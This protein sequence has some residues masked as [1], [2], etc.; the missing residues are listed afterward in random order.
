MK[1]GIIKS[2]IKWNKF[3]RLISNKANNIYIKTN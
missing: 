3:S 1:I 2:Q